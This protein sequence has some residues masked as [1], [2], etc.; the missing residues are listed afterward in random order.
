MVNCSK[1][2]FEDIWIQPASGDSGSALGAA[3]VAWH[4]H[5]GKERIVNINDSMKGTFLGPEFSNEEITKYLNK[6]N[7]LS[8]LTMNLI[9]LVF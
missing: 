5:N 8:E 3:L 2:I 9:Y 4:Q 6:I 1:K 7:I